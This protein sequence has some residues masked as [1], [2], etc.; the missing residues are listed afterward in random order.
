[1]KRITIIGGGASGTLLAV[2]LLKYQGD[3]RI[4]VNLVEKRS[5]VGHGVAFSTQHD[6]H[7]LNVPVG[8]MGALPQDIEHFHKWLHLEGHEY[9]PNAFVPRKMFGEYL[10]DI[11]ETA[12]IQAAPNVVLNVYDDEAVDVHIKDGKAE[13]VFASGDI[14]YSEAVVLAFGNFLPPHP[15]VS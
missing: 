14:L 13:V 8:K 11:L 4:E 3:E 2:N 6:V 10:R 7:L 1:M 15:S 9:E 12:A 5:D